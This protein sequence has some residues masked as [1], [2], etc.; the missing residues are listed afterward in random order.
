M[1]AHHT[2]SLFVWPTGVV[3]KVAV[4]FILIFMS[5]ELSSPLYQVRVIAQ[6]T[7]GSKSTVTNVAS[8]L[9]AIAFFI[10]RSW[11]PPFL[12]YAY[13]S[14]RP[15]AHASIPLWQRILTTSTVPLPAFLNTVWTYQIVKIAIAKCRP[16]QS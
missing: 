16:K 2:I 12:L 5:S 1:I 4:P 8:L 6:N 9:F 13:A 15:W 14:M 10:V 3:T 11:T 7:L